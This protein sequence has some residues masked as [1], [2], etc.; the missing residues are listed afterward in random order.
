MFCLTL[1]FKVKSQSHI[2]SI[3][4]L[5]FPDIGLINIDMKF[6]SHLNQEILKHVQGSKVTISGP[7]R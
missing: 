1:N 5:E 6:L 2:I 7:F 3:Y 4:F